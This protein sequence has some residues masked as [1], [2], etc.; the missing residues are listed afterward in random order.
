MTN[1]QTPMVKIAAI[2]VGHWDLVIG[3]SMVGGTPK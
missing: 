2:P 1:D 3:H